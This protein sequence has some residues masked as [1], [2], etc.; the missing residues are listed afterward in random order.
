MGRMRT[1]GALIAASLAVTA[2]ACDSPH[3]PTAGAS[4]SQVTVSGSGHV[5]G[6]P[7]T[8]TAEVAIEFAAA[9]VTATMKQ[10]NDRQQGVINALADAGVDR[11]DIRTTEV[12]V[13][14]QYSNPNPAGAST[15]ASYRADN[16]IEVKIR[17]PDAAS[18]LLALIVS[19]GGNATRIRSVNYSIADDSQ[20]VRDARS[21]AFHD[22]KNRA[23]QYAELSGRHLGSTLF[24]S[25]E[26]GSTPATPRGLSAVPLEPGR[27]TITFSVTVSWELN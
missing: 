24:I 3:S 7:D 6:V 1:A 11:T 22:A 25:E 21:R 9:D 18:R 2:T 19:T 16:A 23:Q 13:A 20:L 27:Q 26:P 12:T 10:T 4:P 14:P 15:I 8:L 5:E 17:P